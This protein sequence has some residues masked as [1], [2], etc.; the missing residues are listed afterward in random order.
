MTFDS[1]SECVRKVRARCARILHIT[2]CRISLEHKNIKLGLESRTQILRT[3]REISRTSRETLTY[4][5]TQQVR[6]SSTLQDA[7]DAM[8]TD[9]Y[10][11]LESWFMLQNNR[12]TY[13]E[14]E[15]QLKRSSVRSFTAYGCFFECIK[16]RVQR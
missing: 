3:S 4:A 15:V 10:G 5:R 6:W 11:R 1:A 12:A 7:S 9:G 14:L 2:L 16:T 13:K 8:S